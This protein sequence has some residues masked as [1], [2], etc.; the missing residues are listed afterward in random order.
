MS[1]L[2]REGKMTRT[3]VLMLIESVVCI[4]IVIMLASS[5]VKIYREGI[6]R[7]ALD[8][9]ANVYTQEAIKE[10]ITPVIPVFIMGVVITIAGTVLGV[11]NE[12]AESQVKDT[13]IARDLVCERVAKPSETMVRERALQ[14]KLILGGRA[15]ALLCM[16]PVLIYLI[17][18]AHFDKSD[19]EG[20][21][22][23][24]RSMVGFIV[25]FVIL[26]FAILA[27][28]SL[29]AEK[30]MQRESEAASLRIKE[31]KEAGTVKKMEIKPL[32]AHTPPVKNLKTVQL[33]VFTLAIICIIAGV[34]NQSMRDVLIKAINVCSEC[35]G[36]G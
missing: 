30:S 23:V 33:I 31:E 36:L 35:I 32:A 8:P 25:P 21:E 19:V 15:G 12:K 5:A 3:K 6:E 14:K 29:L 34:I 4:L 20:L 24:I 7:K 13:E 11:R 22:M 10:G 2:H 16:V 26:A 1:V 18:P 28:T 27:V 17:D 9:S